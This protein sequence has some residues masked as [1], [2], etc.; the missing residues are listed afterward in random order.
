MRLEKRTGVLRSAPYPVLTRPEC[1]WCDGAW[2]GF[3]HKCWTE[4]SAC[5]G[6]FF[7]PTL[8]CLNGKEVLSFPY[9]NT[10]QWLTANWNSKLSIPLSWHRVRP[11][12]RTRPRH[13]CLLSLLSRALPI[14]LLTDLAHHSTGRPESLVALSQETVVLLVCAKQLPRPLKA[15]WGHSWEL[16]KPTGLGAH[17]ARTA[18]KSLSPLEPSPG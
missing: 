11:E 4:S 6:L 9:I 1:C 15:E 18:L 10:Q 3:P 2:Q 16:L 8:K 5:L 7:L 14:I 12:A 13:C 17:P